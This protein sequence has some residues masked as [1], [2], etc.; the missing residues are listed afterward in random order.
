MRVIQKVCKNHHQR[1]PARH[2]TQGK[3]IGASCAETCICI[4]FLVPL[5]LSLMLLQELP[6]SPASRGSQP[7]LHSG[8][9]WH[10]SQIL[11][12]RFFPRSIKVE[13]L[14]VRL[15]HILSS[16]D[17]CDMQP[18]LRNSALFQPN[19]LRAVHLLQTRAS[20]CSNCPSQ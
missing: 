1:F 19:T 4:S 15:G 14:E 2:A 13:S 20:S 18:T 12:S 5:L 3:L 9:T 11:I 16:P 8:I 6:S 10:I 7:W 17:N